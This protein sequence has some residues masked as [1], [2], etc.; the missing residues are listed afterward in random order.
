MPLLT[1][2]C[3]MLRKERERE[4]RQLAGH[5]TQRQNELSCY[6]HSQNP[7]DSMLRKNVG[8]K[9]AEPY[10][11]LKADIRRLLDNLAKKAQRNVADAAPAEGG[12]TS[13]NGMKEHRDGGV[14]GAQN[15]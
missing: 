2:V 15:R 10:R 12:D 7:V 13:G 11:R 14:P 3:T 4:I 1:P 5:D 6:Q 9:A 8:Y